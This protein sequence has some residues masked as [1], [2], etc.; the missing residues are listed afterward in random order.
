[1]D[2]A[3]WLQRGTEL[4]AAG[5]LE[6]ALFAFEQALA[7]SPTDVN[8][9]SAC[10]TLLSLLDRPAAARKT[11]L[12]VETQLM[13]DA[14]GAANL[15][16]AAEACGDLATAD[17]AYARA[18]QLDPDHLRSLNNVAILTAN[19]SQWDIAIGLARKC[20]ALQPRH[21][22]YHANLAEYLCGARRYA[23]A[24]DAVT[25]ALVEFPLDI[26][27]KVRRA[28][29]LAFHGELEKSDAA[30]TSLEGEQRRLFEEFLLKL[31]APGDAHDRALSQA[32]KLALQPPDALQIHIDQALRNIATGDWRNNSRL[33]TLLRETLANNT[34]N[35]LNRHWG[36][37][38]F[39]GLLLDLQ[40]SELA[41]MRNES[42]NAIAARLKASLP[43]FAAR[44]KPADRQDGRIRVGLAVQSLHDE[45]Q[46]Q[47][48]KQQL[49]LHDTSRFAVHVYAFTPQPGP[50]SGDVLRAHAE[51]VNEIGHMTGA[52]A[53]ARI[54][55]DRLD[56][57][58]EMGFGSPWSRPDIAALRVAAVQLHQPGLYRRH[59]PG[60]WDYSISDHFSHPANLAHPE[61]AQSSQ[62]GGAVVRLP[63]SCWL[64]SAGRQPPHEGKS[65]EEMGLPADALVL[66]SFASPA[67]LDPRSF[68]VWMKILR[69]LPDVVLW[70]PHSA[71]AAANLAREAQAA[72]VGPARLLFST[73]MEQP[74][75]LAGLRHV[76]LVL[77]TLQI[78]AM[79]GLEDALHLCVPAISCAGSRVASRLGGGMLHA[80]GLAHCVLDSPE[81]YQ[82]EAVRLGRNPQALQQLRQ[83][84][85]AEK[86][87]APLFDLAARVREWEAAWATMAECTRAGL[88]PAAFDVPSCASPVK[89]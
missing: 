5:Q 57:Y 51:S 59:V 23:E 64:A 53:A 70:L 20:I 82:A 76:D 13:Q 65:R 80:A 1:M 17:A 24:L 39:Y 66:A 40:E 12:S 81:A 41:Q 26:D 85:L 21:A 79:Q 37:A 11:L 14:D 33:V 50:Q 73:R 46:L 30:L 54:R 34:A 27:L 22:P 86:A 2:H 84:L 18:L 47:A 58:V 32:G 3:G 56:V 89:P 55:L 16:I 44:Q 68:S 69:S 19:S 15:A 7:L 43:V 9:A 78:N 4:H 49:A 62:D 60:H 83:H 75:A 77:D 28:V 48:L 31:E 88:A 8:T 45:R 63:H 87:N 25:A 10:A 72:G 52:E 36:D 6:Q 35:G 67:L 74:Q 61:V 29:L 38:P 71:A 42:F